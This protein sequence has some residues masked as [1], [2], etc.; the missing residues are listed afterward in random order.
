MNN[1]EATEKFQLS[2]KLYGEGRY[3]ESLN[4]LNELGNAF[5]GMKNIL[6]PRALCLYKLERLD[7]AKY[8]CELL[9]DKFSD[10]RAT[11]L[12]DKVKAKQL[13]P[14]TFSASGLAQT[15]APPPVP[16]MPPQ[17]PRQQ[18]PPLPPNIM[19]TPNFD[20]G[21]TPDPM[22]L[23]LPGQVADP[24]GLDMPGLGGPSPLD[25]ILG[26]GG[27][28]ASSFNVGDDILGVP[29]RPASPVPPPKPQSNTKKVLV[30]GVGVV[31]VLVVVALLALP[32]FSKGS[33]TQQ[34]AAPTPNAAP[35]GETSGQAAAQGAPLESFEITW[36]TYDEYLDSTLEDG[37][38]RP[39]VLYFYAADSE[40]CEKMDR[41]FKED[42]IVALTQ[43]WQFIKVDINAKPNTPAAAPQPNEFY[44]EEMSPIER[45]GVQTAPTLV[46]LNE[47][48]A[49]VHRSE[50][51]KLT[52]DVYAALQNLDVQVQN[53]EEVIGDAIQ[54]KHFGLGIAC[55]IFGWV[56]SG[57]F[58][59]YIVLFATGKLPHNSFFDD[60]F[61]VFGTALSVSLAQ[62]LPFRG[63]F[64]GA[65][66]AEQ[67]FQM[68][69]VE[70]IIAEV[71]QYVYWIMTFGLTLAIWG[72]EI[73]AK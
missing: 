32:L 4:I 12:L 5:P 58:A 20:V 31:C 48:G 66:I 41:V 11:S 51:P 57:L 69:F 29:P 18:P 47:W 72:I 50:G 26:T 1:R 8:V 33:Q 62:M 56:T 19:S 53:L 27:S 38:M 30:W 39:T 63:F 24:L 67:E 3:P 71:L 6:Y 70:Y 37:I 13:P 7:E 10:T 73:G 36:K 52:R 44:Y 61:S 40:D 16:S 45:Y 21:P 54:F 9:I 2:Q 42:S 46:V 68:S 14:P 65:R 23:N 25:D 28:Q 22:A 15:M 49:E 43:G 60:I 34:A 17:A 64:L 59:Y 35:S 55:L